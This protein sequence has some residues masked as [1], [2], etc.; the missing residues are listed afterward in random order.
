MV[1]H[2][3]LQS[4]QCT[5]SSRCIPTLVS[6]PTISENFML[7]TY[8]LWWDLP[9][10]QRMLCYHQAP[11]WDFLLMGMAALSPPPWSPT[12]LC[13]EQPSSRFPP[14]PSST[15]NIRRK[16]EN[17]LYYHDYVPCLLY[18]KYQGRKLVKNSIQHG[19]Q[20]PLIYPK[21]Y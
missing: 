12:G 5:Q 21:M 15:V 20:T 17:Y 3:F 13:H 9:L 14:S 2:F 8:Q 16:I 1:K 7:N 19:L 6:S 10:F 4:S 11:G 18:N